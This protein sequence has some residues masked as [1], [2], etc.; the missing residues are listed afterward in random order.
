MRHAPLLALTLAAL[1]TLA[2]AQ[3]QPKPAFTISKETTLVT[4]PLRKD[5]TIDY[6]PVINDIL[7]Q[8]V[9]PENNGATLLL[10]ATTTSANRESHFAVLET[11]KV[12]LPADPPDGLL[13][14]DEF[15][16]QKQGKSLTPEEIESLSALALKCG[17]SPWKAEEYPL[18]ADWLDKSDKSLALV[19]QACEKPH[20]FFPWVS[21]Q[22]AQTA[23]DAMPPLALLRLPTEPLQARAM[24]RAG[25][26][27]FEK[28]LTDLQSER[29]LARFA[30]E[31]RT[32]LGI[33]IAIAIDSRALQAFEGLATSGICTA[34]D[35]KALR[36][37]ISA[38]PPVRPLRD[39]LQIEELLTLDYVMVCLRGHY[40]KL[41]RTQ[42]GI[43]SDAIPIAVGDLPRADW[44][45][46]LKTIRS[47]Y[48]AWATAPEISFQKRLERLDKEAQSAKS[49][50]RPVSFIANDE[51]NLAGQKPV[52]DYLK[53]RPGESRE[54]F[55]I[56]IGQWLAEGDPGMSIRIDKLTERARLEQDLALLTISLAEY[57]LAHNAYPD[58]LKDLPTPVLQDPFSG[59]DIAYRRQGAGFILYSVGFNQ[60]DDNGEGDDRPIRTDR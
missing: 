59:K 52:E 21:K 5:G 49:D 60:K 23:V 3:T 11:L 37:G 42:A 53:M 30:D 13:R 17:K 20:C 10:Q 27:D 31:Q 38:L 54:A 9:T 7:S 34:A 2:P 51:P 4:G 36:N 32:D 6:L 57:K 46:M 28:A 8:G 22:E 35:L 39:A 26:G 43:F 19:T 45:T 55:S 56:R 33:L 16:A 15:A 41:A 58:S 44:D 18:L 12:T 48:A 29:K 40:E 25:K 50:N 47:R 14:I 24:L 1:S